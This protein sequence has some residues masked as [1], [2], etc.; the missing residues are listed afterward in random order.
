MVIFFNMFCRKV[1]AGKKGE[2]VTEAELSQKQIS[3]DENVQDIF[4]S[5]CNI[6]CISPGG[7]KHTGSV[8]V[9]SPVVA[10]RKNKS[11]KIEVISDR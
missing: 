10:A 4:S 5:S 2:S 6:A 11:K 1:N 8:L 3:A 7:K 9:T